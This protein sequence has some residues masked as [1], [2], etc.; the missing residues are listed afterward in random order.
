MD[1]SPLSKALR[2][3]AF[4]NSSRRTRSS[5]HAHEVLEDAAEPIV[6]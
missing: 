4:S 2:S 1:F 6:R 3:A 5:V